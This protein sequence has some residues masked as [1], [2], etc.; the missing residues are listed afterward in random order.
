MTKI[1]IMVQHMQINQ[2][3]KH[4]NKRRVKN[5]MIISIDTEKAF[6]N[7]QHLFMIKTFTEVD[8]EGILSRHNKSHL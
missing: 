3:H 2:C 6:Q 1:T 4:I 5:Y 7:I 8:R